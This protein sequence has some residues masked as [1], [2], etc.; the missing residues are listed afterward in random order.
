MDKQRVS[1]GTVSKFVDKTQNATGFAEKSSGKTCNNH[2]DPWTLEEIHAGKVLFIESPNG[3]YDCLQVSSDSQLVDYA[4]KLIERGRD[5][6]NVAFSDADKKYLYSVAG[7]KIP[8]APPPPATLYAKPSSS[9]K[10]RLENIYPSLKKARESGDICI[11][12]TV[13]WEST[14]TVLEYTGYAKDSLGI[15]KYTLRAHYIVPEKMY[16]FVQVQE[17]SVI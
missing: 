15:I 17:G 6:N 13:V 5:N 9:G 7:K 4:D 2:T 1:V 8:S 12:I 10:R 11:E 14:E 3:L 16:A